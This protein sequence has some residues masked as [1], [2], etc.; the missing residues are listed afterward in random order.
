MSGGRSRGQALSESLIAVLF[1]SPL[2][3]CTLYLVDFH[4]ASHAA[5]IASREIAVTA[6]HAADGR[7]SAATIKA[8]RD[9]TLDEAETIATVRPSAL[10]SAQSPPAV[11]EL[12]S[13]VDI[14]LLP[15]LAMGGGEFD[16]PRFIGQ[17]VR[18]A[19][20]MGST[21][22]L[23]VS[24][25][26]PVE[27]R[28]ELVFAAGHGAS[29]SSAQVRSRTAAISVAGSMAVAAEPL[30]TIATVASVI[31]PALRQLCIG[32]I[33]PDIVPADRLPASV[34]RSNDLRYTPC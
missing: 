31:E 34:S 24:V 11:D 18:S 20:S 26:L 32:R 9:L 28:S 14:L 3:L 23:G 12:A 29:V 4:R 22:L 27:L 7:V 5:E 19:V 17:R 8:I 25:D 30:E 16:V 13:A 6:L 1:L 2:F 10:E 21:T 33:D 15:A